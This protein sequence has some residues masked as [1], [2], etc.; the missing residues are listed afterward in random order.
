M[1]KLNKTKFCG[2]CSSH[3]VYDFPKR[4]FCSMRY[5]QNNDPIVDTLWCCEDWATSGQEC[6]CVREALK[7]KKLL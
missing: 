6:Y 3:N 7:E 2:N 4:Q 5:S 1:K